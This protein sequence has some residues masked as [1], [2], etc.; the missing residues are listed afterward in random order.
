[1][2]YLPPSTSLYVFTPDGHTQEY[3]SGDYMYVL[4][5]NPYYHTLHIHPE[6]FLGL[7]VLMHRQWA[8]DTPEQYPAS[9]NTGEFNPDDLFC[10]DY[11]S[12]LR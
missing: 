3:D 6:D 12:T 2:C 11:F 8:Y 4:I 7:A 1:M 5:H 9:L 10:D